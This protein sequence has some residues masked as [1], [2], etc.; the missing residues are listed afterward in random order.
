MPVQI[1]PFV[2][3][4]V[5]FDSP[6][7]SM[8]PEKLLNEGTI[9]AFADEEDIGWYFFTDG[10]CKVIGQ[11]YKF[12]EIEVLFVLL[13]YFR[14]DLVELGFLLIDSFTE[15]GVGFSEG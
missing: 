15:M 5:F 6:P 2:F 11:I 14:F 9:I 7:G 12:E 8:D 10:D 13:G 4:I 1:D 3:A